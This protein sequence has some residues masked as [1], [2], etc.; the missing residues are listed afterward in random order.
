MKNAELEAKLTEQA[1]ALAAICKAIV[2]VR[3]RLERIEQLLLRHVG[4]AAAA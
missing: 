4:P 3:S 2:E 1:E